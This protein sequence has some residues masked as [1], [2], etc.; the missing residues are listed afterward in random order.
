[1]IGK[2]FSKIFTD[3]PLKRAGRKAAQALLRAA[4]QA[5][6]AGRS[7]LPVEHWKQPH[8]MATVNLHNNRVGRKV[9]REAVRSRTSPAY[10]SIGIQVNIES[11][12]R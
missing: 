7:D 8:I 4:E 1:M 9:K 5:D 3:A 11:I 2:Q 10:S 12:I 6:F